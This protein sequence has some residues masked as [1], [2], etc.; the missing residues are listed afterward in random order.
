MKYFEFNQHEYWALVAA[1]TQEK[2]FAVYVSEVGGDSITQIIEE[3]YPTETTKEFAFGKYIA[4]VAHLPE[5]QG[6]GLI[7]LVN[8]FLNHKNTTVLITSELA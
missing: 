5:N 6:R 8:D 3:G 7:G 2:A 4:A 1:E